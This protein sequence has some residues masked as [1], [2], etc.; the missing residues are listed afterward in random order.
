MRFNVSFLFSARSSFDR[1]KYK[2]IRKFKVR[3]REREKDIFRDRF[4][5]GPMISPK[6]NVYIITYTWQQGRVLRVLSAVI[7]LT[8]PHF[9]GNDSKAVPI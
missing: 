4:L 6:K 9:F 5:I 3:E 2:Y 1:W 7:D 8:Q